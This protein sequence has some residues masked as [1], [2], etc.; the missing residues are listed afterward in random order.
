MLEALN[1]DDVRVFLATMRSRSLRG[2]AETLGVSHPTASRRIRGLE[3]SLGM[4]LFDRRPDGLHPTLEAQEL[5]EAAEEVERAMQRL[6]R[7]AQ[8][9]APELKGPV[10]VTLPQAFATDLLMPDFVAFQERWPEIDLHIQGD[11]DIRDLASREAD[12]ALRTMSLGASP[13]PELAGRRA[14]TVSV[15]LY[16]QGE[17]WIGWRGGR[18]FRGL[19]E[20]ERPELPVRGELPSV[21]LQRAACL[22]GMGMAYLPCFYAEPHLE[23]RSEP[24]PAGELWVLVHPD[25][26]R[27]PRL[28]LFRDEVVAALRRHQPRLSG[29]AQPGRCS[30]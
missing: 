22:A 27:N 8:A 24:R 3:Q 18:T 5:A 16:G 29:L 26:R 21:A 19:G 11:S 14:A 7:V 1:W 28:R 9:A 6:G 4:R 10:R 20:E 15:A 23:R 17:R 30:T 2:V 25:L 12:V 13:D